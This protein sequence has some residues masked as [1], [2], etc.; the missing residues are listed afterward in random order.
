MDPA[1][2]QFLLGDV[3]VAFD[4]D[5]PAAR[6]RLVDAVVHADDTAADEP[7]DD[8]DDDEFEDDDLPSSGEAGHGATVVAEIVER[9]ID[10]RPPE[11]WAAARRLLDAGRTGLAG[12]TELAVAYAQAAETAEAAE[13]PDFEAAFAAQ[14]AALPLPSAGA[15]ADAMVAA[16]RE[17]GRATVDEVFEAA[18]Q[19]TGRPADDPLTEHIFDHV[20]EDLSTGDGLLALLAGDRVVHVEDLTAGIVLTHRITE[21]EYE[22]DLLAVGFDLAGF[23]RRDDVHLRG[24][25]GL[26]EDELDDGQLAWSGPDGWLDDYRPGSLVAVR[27]RLDGLVDVTPLDDEEPALD[28]DLVARLRDV[29]DAEVA[30]PWLPV[31]GED[32]ILGL[33]VDDPETF[34]V[35]R[36]PLDDLCAAAGL[37]RRGEEVAHDDSVWTAAR[38]SRRLWRLHDRLEDKDALRAAARA[39]DAADPIGESPPPPLHQV[40]GDLRDPQVADAVLEALVPPDKAD[41]EDLDVAARFAERLLAAARVPAHTAVARFVAA[42]AAERAGDVFAADAHLALAVDADGGYAPALERAAWYASDRGDAATAVRLWHRLGTADPRDLAEVEPFTRTGSRRPGR[43]EPCWCGSGRKYKTCHPGQDRPVPLPDRVG[44]LCR[45]AVGYLMHRGGAALATS[46][47]MA[48]ARA[49]DPDD[50]TSLAEA[51]DDPIV[52]DAVLT[53]AGWF[54]RFLDDRGPLLPDDEALLGRAWTLVPRTVYEITGVDAGV[55]LTMRDI[56]TGDHLAVRERTF[57]RDAAPGMFV[58]ARAVPDGH[59]HQLIGAVLPVLP[60]AESRVLDLCDERDPTALCRYARALHLPPVLQTREGEPLVA[61]TAVVDVGDP[62]LAR[63]VLDDRYEAEMDGWVET[64]ALSPDDVIL[65][66]QL[67]LDGS[68]LTVTTHSEARLDRV[69]AV[70]RRELPDARVVSE[71]RTPMSAA[72]MASFDRPPQDPLAALGADEQAAVVTGI[73]DHLERRWVDESV[74]A[75][76]GLTPREAADDPTRRA[77]LE[78]LIASM[79]VPEPG[80]PGIAMRP[81]RLRALL[82]LDPAGD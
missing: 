53:E 8:F 49:L 18:A 60:G 69:L 13:R 59:T 34:R 79:P 48:Y 45:K 12:L 37:E 50:P 66:A 64:H 70:L 47:A 67:R 25:E 57:S 28:A 42:V 62:S 2:V 26:D 54:E 36:P 44:W 46:V 7:D 43:N 81:D 74:P 15:I 29:Y 30:E 41:A 72:D 31:A 32:L 56:R 38:Q 35:P 24:G 27:V 65:R 33:L 10:E 78:R 20:F 80:S 39:L 71:E 68:R 21:E 51:I 16:V 52:L 75:L 23:V 58:C 77:E 73:Q 5:D 14:L 17:R 19:R 11:V 4:L 1:K 55:G 22:L 63:K 61:C 3:P 9:V 6:H 40:L 82:G 76:A